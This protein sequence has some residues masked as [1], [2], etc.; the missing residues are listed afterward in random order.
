M[1][2]LQILDGHDIEL[3]PVP[4]PVA[5]RVPILSRRITLSRVWEE[6]Q[7]ETICFDAEGN[8]RPVLF[9]DRNW[10]TQLDCIFLP[11]VIAIRAALARQ[12]W[13]P[14]IPRGSAYRSPLEQARK[15]ALGYSKTLR[16]AHNCRENGQPASRAV[17]MVPARY[18]WNAPRS[19]WLL[20]GELAVKQGLKWGGFFGLSQRER[21]RLRAVLTLDEREQAGVGQV[22]LGWDLAHIE[23][24]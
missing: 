13:Q 3:A 15:V 12:G 14:V 8:R 4:R 1:R 23:R 21:E 10:A 19:Y 7:G 5:P 9:D 20:L 24:V 11:Q 16:S 17:D 18:G 2:D 22:P 6:E